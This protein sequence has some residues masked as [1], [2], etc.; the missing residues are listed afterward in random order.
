M[1]TD[2]L[3]PEILPRTYTVQE[4]S[5]V[6]GYI[7]D[8]TVHTVKPEYKDQKTPVVTASVSAKNEPVPYGGKGQKKMTESF[9]KKTMKFEPCTGEALSVG[10]Y[11]AEDIGKLPKDTCVEILTT[12][13]GHGEASTSV[14]LPLANTT[15]K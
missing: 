11:S 9:N 1:R 4:K 5:T 8:K 3:K 13:A 2:M 7:L 14:K 15:F 12:D 10:V 6:T